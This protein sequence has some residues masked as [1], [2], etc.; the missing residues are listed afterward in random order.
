MLI[1]LDPSFHLNENP[2]NRASI[3]NVY[4]NKKM[5]S[6]VVQYNQLAKNI[7]ILT[8]D[9]YHID[10]PKI[11]FLKLISKWYRSG[12]DEPIQIMF[13]RLNLKYLSSKQLKTFNLNTVEKIHGHVFTS[14]M[15][16]INRKHTKVNPLGYY[17][18]ENFI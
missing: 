3:A 10:I 12:H 16:M 13:E 7:S 14:P 9:P 18:I 2:T 5:Y 8:V 17:E 4:V 15:D 6:G 1:Q 11:E